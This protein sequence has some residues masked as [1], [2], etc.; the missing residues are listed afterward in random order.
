MLLQ[1]LTDLVA[2]LGDP[3]QRDW[4]A[5]EHQGA[6]ATIRQLASWMGSAAAVL[7]G[8]DDGVVAVSTPDPVTHTVAVLG[9]MAA[10]R[11]PLLIDPRHPDR[12]AAEVATRAG[13]TTVVGRDIAGLS[14]VEAGELTERR[15]VDRRR[16]KPDSAGT[17][18]L[19]SGSTGTPKLVLRSRAADL[20]GAK[21]LSSSGFAIGPGDRYW[22]AAPFTGSPFPG[23]VMAALLARATVVFA[24]F[25]LGSVGAFL[26]EHR[27][28][29]MYLGATPS[30]LVHEREG[31]EGPGW[32]G[33]RSVLSGGERLDG[34]T[35]ALMLERFPGKVCLGY[36]STE[37]TLVAL[38]SA[39]DLRDRPGT[40]GQPLPLHQMKIAGADPDGPTGP[41]VAGEVLM[42]GGSM[43]S[44]YVGGEDAGDW[45]RSGDIG[46]L[47]DD[48]YLYIIGRATNVVQVGGNRVSTDEVTN[49][50]RTHPALADAMVIAVDDA[51]WGARLEAFVVG[52]RDAADAAA[53]DPWLRERL[54]AYKVPRAFHALAEMPVDSSGK[55]SLR[56][57]QHLATTGAGSGAR[58]SSPAGR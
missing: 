37:V 54:P 26:A 31:L 41:G 23:I 46:H 36:G 30:R 18:L 17:I 50:L 43:Y 49:V 28:T 16:C 38:A 24:P 35:A 44:G 4:V 5:L 42:R 33:L 57:L 53:L 39:A 25:E 40:V 12:L 20:H 6:T 27:I 14:S 10:G 32:D 15:P 58:G 48:G 8:D 1:D 11:T 2:M 19:T 22:L 21:G 47:D 52:P 29:S 13:A 3:S 56:A 55:T 34:D 9:A 51:T 7:G 45:Y